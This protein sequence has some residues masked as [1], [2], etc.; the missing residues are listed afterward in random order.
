MYPRLFA[1]AL[2]L[3]APLVA[4]AAPTP[5]ADVLTPFGHRPAANVHHVPKGASV[6]HVGDEVHIIDATGAVI[7]KTTPSGNFTKTV[8]SSH[9]GTLQ[10]GWIA[11]AYW[12]NTLT[13]PIN[14]FT[15]TWVVPSTPASVDGQT[16]FLFNSI[17]PSS[18]NAI[19]QPVL[20]FGSSAAGGGNYWAVANWYGINNVYYY[21]ALQTVSTGQ[22]LQGVI[23]LTNPSTCGSASTCNYQSAFSGMSNTMS[24]TGSAQLTWAT[25]TLEAYNLVS[26]KDFPPVSMTFGNIGITTTAGSPSVT[27]SVVDST[28]DNVDAIVLR[29]GSTNAA[30]EILYHNI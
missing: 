20:Q 4:I 7:H 1:L 6:H 27:W 8:P 9:P 18:G 14:Y 12:L 11:Y 24:V 23:T 25:E 28:T 22:S 3:V 21:T 2:G 13:T 29:Q 26:N 16:V 19:L 5:A 10:T 15:S 17:E 30:V